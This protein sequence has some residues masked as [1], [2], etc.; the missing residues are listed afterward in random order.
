MATEPL[1]RG[2]GLLEPGHVIFSGE[3]SSA[4]PSTLTAVQASS[5]PAR[6]GYPSQALN[7]QADWEGW[8]VS[9]WHRAAMSRPVRT[10][11][12]FMLL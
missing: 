4:S 2:D 11:S 1:L 12:P 9:P 8:E 5:L 7:Y 6:T 10:R 3:S